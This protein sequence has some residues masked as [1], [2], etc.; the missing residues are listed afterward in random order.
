MLFPDLL[1]DEAMSERWTKLARMGVTAL[2]IAA[3]TAALVEL[4]RSH[5]VTGISC[6]LAWL[7]VVQVERRW[8]PAAPPADGAPPAP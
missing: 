7:L 2:R 3:S 4:L 6:S 1:V 8:L 5:W